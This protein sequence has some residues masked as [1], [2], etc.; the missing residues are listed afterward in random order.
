MAPAS[1]LNSAGQRHDADPVYYSAKPLGLPVRSIPQNPRD[2]NCRLDSCGLTLLITLFYYLGW[3]WPAFSM[4]LLLAA[5]ATIYSP[6]KYGYLKE[7]FGKERL[8][9]ANGVMSAVSMIAILGGILPTPLR[10]KFSTL[11]CHQRGRS[12]ARHCTGWLVISLQFIN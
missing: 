12:A 4:T 9:Q 11:K 3:F 2:A 6:A 7:L 1:S 10:L 8:G 5:Q